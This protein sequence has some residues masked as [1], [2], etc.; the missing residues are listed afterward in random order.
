MF[1][2]PLHGQTG[3]IE[4]LPAKLSAQPPRAGLSS[5]FPEQRWQQGSNKAAL[6]VSVEMEAKYFSN[7]HIYILGI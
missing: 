6:G 5:F 2:A 1:A 4:S 7:L 3:A